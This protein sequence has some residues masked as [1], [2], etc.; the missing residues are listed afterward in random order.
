MHAFFRLVLLLSPVAR[1]CRLLSLHLKRSYR[2]STHSTSEGSSAHLRQ[3]FICVCTGRRS[4]PQTSAPL[5]PARRSACVWRRS[6][7]WRPPQNPPTAARCCRQVVWCLQLAYVLIK[8]MQ[9]DMLNMHTLSYG[10]QVA[11]INQKHSTK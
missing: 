11:Q 9:L 7:A 2:G 5:H 6:A 8:H 3:I 4:R 1:R 10:L